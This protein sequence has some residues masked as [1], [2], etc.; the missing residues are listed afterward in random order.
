MR[1]N[2]LLAKIRVWSDGHW[3]ALLIWQAICMSGVLY[4]LAN[5]RDI[6]GVHWAQHGYCLR[7]SIVCIL[8]LRKSGELFAETWADYERSLLIV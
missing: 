7:E 5:V 1:I 4:G 6:T 3:V 8:L 2:E